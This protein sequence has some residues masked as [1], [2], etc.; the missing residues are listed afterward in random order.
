MRFL[1]RLFVLR[2]SSISL[3]NIKKSAVNSHLSQFN[4]HVN[5]RCEV[6]LSGGIARLELEVRLLVRGQMLPDELL[7]LFE[8]GVVE[9]GLEGVEDLDGYLARDVRELVVLNRL[10]QGIEYLP[11]QN[12]RDYR[13]QVHVPVHRQRRDYLLEQL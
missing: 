12:S 9:Y 1:F 5:N 8:V 2:S 10:Q 13:R 11:L 6:S 4:S 7:E 3:F